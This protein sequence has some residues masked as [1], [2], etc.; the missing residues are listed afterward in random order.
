MT[1]L[2]Y[3]ISPLHTRRRGDSRVKD[4]GSK[5]IP[6]AYTVGIGED[7]KIHS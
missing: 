1:A 3:S 2:A 5:D 4:Q 7:K 6:D